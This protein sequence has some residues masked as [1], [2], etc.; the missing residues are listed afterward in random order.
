MVGFFL[1]FVL[2]ILCFVGAAM[3]AS[4]ALWYYENQKVLDLANHIKSSNQSSILSTGMGKRGFSSFDLNASINR[5]KSIAKGIVSAT[6]QGVTDIASNVKKS[7]FFGTVGMATKKTAQGITTGLTSLVKPV[8]DSEDQ[9]Q[10]EVAP[11]PSVEEI[12]QQSYEADV[13]KLIKDAPEE[14]NNTATLNLA[15]GSGQVE[16]ED[17]TVFEKLELRILNRLKE[18]GMTNYDIWIEL[19]ALYKKFGQ[20]EKAKEV[21]AL[22]L[23]HAGDTNKERARNELI[24]MS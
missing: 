1:W 16:A 18:S 20:N 5:S 2:A 7:N 10:S 4:Y 6:V 12:K 23:K 8:K 21:F 11:A 22:V 9:M 14:T 24:G 17:L 15:K 13:D 19:G 3:L